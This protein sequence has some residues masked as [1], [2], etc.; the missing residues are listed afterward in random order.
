MSNSSRPHGLQ[1]SRLLRPWDFP[2]KS[3]GVGC[4]C[5]L[6]LSLWG[7]LKTGQGTCFRRLFPA[8]GVHLAAAAHAV[9][10]DGS[11][12]PLGLWSVFPGCPL[13]PPLPLPPARCFRMACRALQVLP[14]TTFPASLTLASH[15][16]VCLQLAVLPFASPNPESWWLLLNIC[17]PSNTASSRKPS[18]TV[19]EIASILKHTCEACCHPLPTL[20]SL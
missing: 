7:P 14:P 11:L 2:G 6:H 8:A 5:L 20:G 15:L 4:H 17:L 13:V 19:L 3:T 10:W 18:L 9:L 12:L 1:P 16:C